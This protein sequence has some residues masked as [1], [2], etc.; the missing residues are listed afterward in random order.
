[1]GNF[2]QDTPCSHVPA[3][4]RATMENVVGSFNFDPNQLW[5]SSPPNNVRYVPSPLPPLREWHFQQQQQ[6]Q[7]KCRKVLTS[8]VKL[9]KLTISFVSVV[10]QLLKS[11][12]GPQPLEPHNIKREKCVLPFSFD[13]IEFGNGNGNDNE[14]DKSHVQTI[15][16]PC[17]TQSDMI[18][19]TCITCSAC[20]CKRFEKYHWKLR[21]QNKTKFLDFHFHNIDCKYSPI[22]MWY[23]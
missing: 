4:K 22:K 21:P 1:M 19:F 7:V 11:Y 13:K 14:E 15:N 18:V 10:K 6:Q 20:L 17:C 16:S 3:S 8:I 12:G 5:K 23:Q 2:G 9:P